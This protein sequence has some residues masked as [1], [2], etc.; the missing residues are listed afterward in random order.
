M[1]HE[2]KIDNPHIAIILQAAHGGGINRDRLIAA[3]SVFIDML[4]ACKNLLAYADDYSDTMAKS[5][6]GAEQLGKLADS[7]SVASQARSAI[8]L[9]DPSTLAYE[10]AIDDMTRRARA[11]FDKPYRKP[12][13]TDEAAK[14]VF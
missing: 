11:L 4:E 14:H 8:A 9:A 5:G 3:A 2:Q 13:D 10:A 6:H 7:V 1:E 12:P